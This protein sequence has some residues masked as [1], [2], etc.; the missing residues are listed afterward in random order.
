MFGI[1]IDVVPNLPKFPVPVLVYYRTYRRIRYWY[2]C[3]TDISEASGTG[4]DVV[5]NLLKRPA[6]VI[7]VIYSGVM[8]RTYRVEHTTVQNVPFGL[9]T[10][11]NAKTEGLHERGERRVICISW[12][13]LMR[14]GFQ[15]SGFGRVSKSN[16]VCAK[17]NGLHVLNRMQRWYSGHLFVCS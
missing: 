6:P 4:I 12:A 10:E 14:V 16:L 3:R 8:S 11:K 7:P 1:G 2:W 13:D 17:P 15:G 5:P 9:S